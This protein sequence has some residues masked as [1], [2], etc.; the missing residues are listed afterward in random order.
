MSTSDLDISSR[1]G[2]ELPEG[3]QVSAEDYARYL[4]SLT[5]GNV[6]SIAKHGL[7]FRDPGN[8]ETRIPFS[9]DGN[10]LSS[11]GILPYNTSLNAVGYIDAHRK[12][13]LAFRTDDESKHPDL[14][15]VYSRWVEGDLDL[16]IVSK[17]PETAAANGTPPK[18]PDFRKLFG[19]DDPFSKVVDNRGDGFDSLYGVRNFRVV[20]HGIFY[21]G[22]ANNV[23][24]KFGKKNNDNPLP[25][26]GLKNLCEN[27]FS[28]AVYFYSTN[29]Q[30]SPSNIS[31]QTADGAHAFEYQQISVLSGESYLK[32]LA[33]IYERIQA[34][35]RGPIYGHCWNGWHPSGLVSAIA[36]RQFCGYSG[37]EAESYWVRNTDGAS[38]GYS[39]IRQKIRDFSPLEK[40]KVSAETQARICPGKSP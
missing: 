29:F 22:G 21:R 10:E 18:L 27:G 6:T 34:P 9:G 11:R 37:E 4:S 35:E 28:S 38:T 2:T 23:F 30:S 5:I 25:V 19:V 17:L 1:D 31:C 33:M 39:H 32:I 26:G 15:M 40:W 12:W 13:L 24:N 20:L 14:G 8:P 16:P 36:L 3:I 7:N